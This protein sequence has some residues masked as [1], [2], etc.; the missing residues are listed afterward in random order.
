MSIDELAVE[1][2]AQNIQALRDSFLQ[3][4]DYQKVIELNDSLIKKDEELKKNAIK[5]LE[6]KT[7]AE[8][9]DN[10][11]RQLKRDREYN[12]RRNKLLWVISVLLG[13]G[14]VFFVLYNS[15]KRKN[16]ARQIALM[17]AEKEEANL[18][19]KLKEEQAVQSELQKYEV[20]SQFNLKEQELHG[21]LEDFEQLRKEKELLDR[22]IEDYRQSIEAFESSVEKSVSENNELQREITEEL[23]LHIKKYL[24]D[25]E[26]YV[27]N[28]ENIKDDFVDNIQKTIDGNLSRQYLKYCICF[29]VEMTVKDVSDC[30]FVEQSSVH[31]I[32]YRLKK[33][34]NLGNDDNIDLYLKKLSLQ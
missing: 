13:L 32:R 4:G 34:F 18:Q 21:K 24:P 14:A 16:I 6:L 10:E 9:K 23:K 5:E 3:A 12:E 2:S 15:S 31:M 8:A 30:C 29:A 28:I 19:L 33:K 25:T 1:S 20:L 22:R 17:N 27:K 26:E 7:A 11:Y